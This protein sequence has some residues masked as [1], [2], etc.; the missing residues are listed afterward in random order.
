MKSRHLAR[1]TG[2]WR[3]HRI[4]APLAFGIKF[5]LPLPVV[6]APFLYRSR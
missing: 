6:K 5:P 2:A 1:H 3:P 4:G